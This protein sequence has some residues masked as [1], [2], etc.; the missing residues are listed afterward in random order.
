MMEEVAIDLPFGAKVF[1]A[2]M[3]EGFVCI[4][5]IVDTTAPVTKRHFNLYKT[6]QE[7]KA[8]VNYLH[9]IG[10]AKVNVGMDLGMH[11][12]ENLKKV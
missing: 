10:I 4:W 1:N 5:A 9:Y 6:G 8:D 11:V 7:I 12:F 2:E 3:Q